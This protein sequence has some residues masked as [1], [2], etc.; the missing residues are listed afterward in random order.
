MFGS[1]KT[2]GSVAH[3]TAKRI[4]SRNFKSLLIVYLEQ[5]RLNGRGELQHPATSKMRRHAVVTIAF[6]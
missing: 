1:R 4:M 5:E 2:L 3:L 6:L